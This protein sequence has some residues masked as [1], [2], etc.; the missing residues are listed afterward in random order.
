MFLLVYIVQQI[1]QGFRSPIV[2]EISRGFWNYMVQEIS[3]GFWNYMMQ[4]ISQSFRKTSQETQIVVFIIF[5]I[6]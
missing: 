5:F 3:Q 4:E 6:P 1:C 2:Q